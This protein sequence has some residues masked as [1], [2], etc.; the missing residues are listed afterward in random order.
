MVHGMFG[1]S[2]DWF[3]YGWV[4]RLAPSHTLVVIDMRGHGLSDKPTKIADY[5]LDKMAEDVIAVMDNEKNELT[6]YLGFSGLS[7]NR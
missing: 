5:S 3:D 4:E 1:R 2:Q 7:G 6:D